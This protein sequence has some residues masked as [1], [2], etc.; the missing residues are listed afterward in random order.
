MGR[1]N[2]CGGKS[3]HE[4]LERKPAEAKRSRG[5]AAKL[6]K[7]KNTPLQSIVVILLSFQ[8]VKTEFSL[9]RNQNRILKRF[10]RKILHNYTGLINVTTGNSETRSCFKKDSFFKSFKRIDGVVFYDKCFTFACQI[11]F[12]YVLVKLPFI[13]FFKHKMIKC[14]V[15]TT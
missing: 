9:S 1:G 11:N 13:S 2:G 10:R 6:L 15:L 12:I 3:H 8:S 14:L 7:T 4:F 5:D